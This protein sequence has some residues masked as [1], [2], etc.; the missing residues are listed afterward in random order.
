M[1]DIISNISDIDLKSILKELNKGCIYFI[2]KD[3]E[4]VND[5]HIFAVNNGEIVSNIYTDGR[6]WNVYG[7]TETAYEI[8][9]DVNKKVFLYLVEDERVV[10]Q[11]FISKDSIKV[12]GDTKELNKALSKNRDI[13]R[14]CCKDIYINT[15]HIKYVQHVNK[16]K[17]KDFENYLEEGKYY[18][19]HINLSVLNIYRNGYLVYEGKKPIM[20]TYEDNY[21]ILCGSV[22]YRK[23]K[24]LMEKSISKVDIYQYRDDF[25]KT[26]LERHPEMRIEYVEEGQK[27]MDEMI[28][29]AQD[30]LE[31]ADTEGISLEDS[32]E[33]TLSKEELLKKFG[34]MEPDE[35]WVDKVLKGAYA[36]SLEEL[37]HLKKEIEEEIV[38]R[39]GKM[40]GVK[41]VKVSLEI[42]WEDGVYFIEGDVTIET[43][44]LF[45][46]VLG[47]VNPESIKKEID[48]IIKTYVPTEYSTKLFISVF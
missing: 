36:P 6:L 19:V 31:V 23:I 45:G 26:L 29:T 14:V 28:D 2:F 1:V 44:K 9:L 12:K 40:K 25:V 37:L 46:I 41:K 27:K 32:G 20:A 47:E 4:E 5:I 7:D 18:L 22:A 38:K 30:I 16:N 11:L 3:K 24:K 10:G 42:T 15:P 8:V 39:C 33:S 43:K 13:L 35:N 21:G 34:L 48:N 17:L